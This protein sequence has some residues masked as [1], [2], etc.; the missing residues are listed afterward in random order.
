MRWLQTLKTSRTLKTSWSHT[1]TQVSVP[2]WT[3]SSMRFIA[4]LSTWVI[5]ASCRHFTPAS[6]LSRKKP[7]CQAK[8]STRS[9]AGP[10]FLSSYVALPSFRTRARWQA[11]L[12]HSRCSV[13]YRTCS[14]SFLNYS[15]RQGSTLPKASL[16]SYLSLMTTIERKQTKSMALYL[17]TK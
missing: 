15:L 5:G 10:S 6:S 8:P 16:M 9:C 12:W 1:H 17:T 2:C 7:T 3:R 11:Q 4:D 14:T 13:K